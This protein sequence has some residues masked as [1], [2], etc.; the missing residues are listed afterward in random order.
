VRRTSHLNITWPAGRGQNAV[1]DAAA[2]DLIT[3]RHGEALITAEARLNVT[4]NS[5]RMLTGIASTPR[6]DDL[7]GLVGGNGGS[8]FR[9]LLRSVA[10]GEED[11]GSPLHFLLDDI[12]GVTLV[13]PSCWQ[14]WPGVTPRSAEELRQRGER[15]GGVCSGFRPDGP[16]IQRLLSGMRGRAPEQENLPP[17]RDLGPPG[18]PLA[19][20]LIA[21]PPDGPMMRR[22]RI[23][24]VLPA[25]SAITVT[26]LFRD[27]IW[28]PGRT[29]RV[30][31]E[32][33]LDA[34]IDPATMRLTGIRADPHVL[35]FETCPA[36]ARNTDL[37]AG[38]PVR[39]LRRRV[40]D[41][42]VG[43]DGC[44]HL[45]DA[46]RALAEVPVLLDELTHLGLAGWWPPAAWRRNDT[47]GRPRLR[48]PPPLTS[49]W[50]CPRRRRT[51]SSRPTPAAGW[52]P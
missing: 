27:S 29:E 31:H 36:A 3:P 46:L 35:P 32:Y 39:T 33:A 6:V 41:L 1:I 7:L 40:L 15:M 28:G 52:S 45:T 18:D 25:D 22:R 17:A 34:S 24:D 9:K 4:V 37:L 19:W 21:P 12:P 43:T 13:G 20:H 10:P 2:R 44:T 23:V 8:G 50:R 38:E 47:T 14:L 51:A 30:V 49:R 16:P 11:A 5:R 42:I 48:P 26:A